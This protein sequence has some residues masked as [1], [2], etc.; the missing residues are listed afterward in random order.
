LKRLTGILR[1]DASSRWWR[2]ATALTL[3]RGRQVPAL[4]A[5]RCTAARGLPD[6]R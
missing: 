1:S 4:I 5:P 3:R 2:I 6:F